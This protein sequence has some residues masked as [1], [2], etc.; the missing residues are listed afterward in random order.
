MYS[1]FSKDLEREVKKIAQ[2][3]EKDLPEETIKRITKQ[4]TF[5]GMSKNPSN[6][7]V[8]NK[9]GPNLLRKGEIG[10]WKNYFTPEQNEKF[11]VQLL[12]NLEGTGLQFD[13]GD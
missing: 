11:E 5:T 2:F 13:F 7:W 9:D 1:F 10:D 3:L 4:C 12:S 6:Y 8:S